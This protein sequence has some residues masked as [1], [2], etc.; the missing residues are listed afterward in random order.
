MI[1]GPQ[2]L[3]AFAMLSYREN[4]FPRI[5]L[6][7][8]HRKS[9]IL[10]PHKHGAKMENLK[11]TEKARQRKRLF[12][13]GLQWL[14]QNG[15]SVARAHGIGKSSVRDITRGN[16]GVRV[17]IKTTQDQYI[18]FAPGHDGKGWQTLDD[19]D[20]VVVVSV[21]DKDPPQEA[22]VHWFG[23]DDLRERFDRALVAR[24][25]AGYKERHDRGVWLPLYI[26][27]DGQVVRFVGGGIGLE[28]PPIARVPLNGGA[29]MRNGYSMMTPP[30][31]PRPSPTHGAPAPRGLT[32]ADAKRGLAITFG[33]PES[34][35]RITIEA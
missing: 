19:V 9:A 22:L 26:A 35:V 6:L 24:E 12:K 29:T 1:A 17:S 18:A 30:A 16:D 10:C 25:E 3:F 21:D 31:P 34:A 4:N 8:A 33:V 11:E 23:A 2:L 20:A 28:N 32:I 7:T 5:C 27:D 15:W 13:I 14:E